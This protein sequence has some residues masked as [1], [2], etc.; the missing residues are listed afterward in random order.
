MKT[1]VYKIKVSNEDKVKLKDIQEKYSKDFRRVY[2]NLELS[3]DK[4]FLSSLNMKSSK[5]KEYL[6]KEVTS[7]WEKYQSTKNKIRQ[8]LGTDENLSFKKITELKRSL[9][10]DI[11]FGG[12]E[13]LKRRTKGLIS[14]SEWKELRLYPIVFYGETSRKGNRFFNFKDLSNGNILFKL[15][16]TD[17]KIPIKISNKKHSK[18][19]RL[20][21]DLCLT[22][23][24]SLTVKLTHDKIYLTFDETI[25]NGTNFDYRLHQKDKPKDLNKLE[26]KEYWKSKY[27]EHEEKLKSGKLERYLSIDVNPNEIGFSISDDKLNILDRGCYQITGKVNENKRK[28]EYSQIIKELFK[29]VKHFKISYFVI[30][31]LELNK[32]NYGNK[33]S[34]RK[35]KLEFKKNY[36]FSII[37]RRCNETGTV[38]R[39]VNP[40]YSSFIGNLMYKEYDP[41]SSSM[42]ILR[43]GINQ[44]NKGFKLIPELDKDKIITDKIDDSLDLNQFNGFTDLFKSIRNKSYRRKEISFSSQKFTK[45]DK[46]HVCLCF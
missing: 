30:E 45:S 1:L 10:S 23:G 3:Q 22:K 20:L 19:L 11:C 38:L 34:N 29:K 43:R 46:S 39:K 7:F 25:L 24:I 31:D 14:N 6:V 33:V 9:K 26:T 16:S 17:V 27:K 4:E 28:H 42:E 40:C 35:N 32:D 41:I 18:E 37:N 12:R 2:K 13:N 36:I 5:L 8:R 15:E 21:E 44:Y